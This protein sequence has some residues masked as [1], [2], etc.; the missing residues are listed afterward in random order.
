[1]SRN[2]QDFGDKTLRNWLKNMNLS[3]G[4]EI[5]NTFLMTNHPVPTKENDYVA[6]QNMILTYEYTTT[7]RNSIYFH[8]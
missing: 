3:F 6:K 4:S 7:M 5:W 8:S 2:E 1:M